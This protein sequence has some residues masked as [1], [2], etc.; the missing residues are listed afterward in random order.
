MQKTVISLA[1]RFLLIILAI[2]ALSIPLIPAQAASAGMLNG[3][4]DLT[5]LVEKVGPAVVNIRTIEKICACFYF[6]GL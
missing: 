5:S 1:K 6:S 2:L 3:L 4:P